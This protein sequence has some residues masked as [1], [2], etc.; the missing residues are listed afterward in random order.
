MFIWSTVGPRNSAQKQ[1]FLFCLEQI[2]DLESWG[3]ACWQGDGTRPLPETASGCAYGLLQS[4]P[5]ELVLWNFP[6]SHL[7]RSSQ[8]SFRRTIWGGHA[9]TYRTH[10][11]HSGPFKLKLPLLAV[12][13]GC[14]SCKHLLLTVARHWLLSPVSLDKL[15]RKPSVQSHP[16]CPSLAVRTASVSFSWHQF[17]KHTCPSSVVTSTGQLRSCKTLPSTTLVA[18]ESMKHQ[19]CLD[20]LEPG[21]NLQRSSGSLT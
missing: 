13:N 12:G 9:V 18:G 17:Y 16:P 20:S 19:P 5:A 14:R 3:T 11:R 10:A 8:R 1:T 21:G 2:W 15:K 7:F 4:R 6:L